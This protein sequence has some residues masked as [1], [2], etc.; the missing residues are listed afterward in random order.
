[1]GLIP[2]YQPNMYSI[3]LLTTPVLRVGVFVPGTTLCSPCASLYAWVRGLMDL[4]VPPRLELKL[5]TLVSRVGVPTAMLVLRASKTES[6]LQGA[7]PTMMEPPSTPAFLPSAFVAC[8]LVWNLM[9]IQLELGGI[10]CCNTVP[11]APNCWRMKLAAEGG[12]PQ[13]VTQVARGATQG[14]PSP[15]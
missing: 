2:P 6:S 3:A 10:T 7:T 9:C 11:Q 12:K 8:S 5:A 13:T 15:S 1:L 4:G 14:S